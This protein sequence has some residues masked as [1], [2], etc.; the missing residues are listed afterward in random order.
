[1]KG[2]MCLQLNGLLN[3]FP[4]GLTLPF[5]MCLQSKLAV[6]LLV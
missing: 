6:F 4:A 5:F 3:L 1:M 2:Q